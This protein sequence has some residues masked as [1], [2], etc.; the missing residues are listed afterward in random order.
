V[1]PIGWAAAMNTPFPYY[2]VIAS[3]LGGTRTGMVI[4]WPARIQAR[5]VRRQFVDITDITPTILDTIG[6]TPPASIA[7]ALQTPF[8][9]VSFADSFSS[10]NAPSHHDTQYFEIFGNAAIYQNGWLL[11]ERVRTDPMRGAA[12]PD[13]T[14]PWQLYDLTHDFSQTVDVASSH[15]D[16]VA[17]MTSLWQTEAARNHVLPL[18]T[19]NLRAMLPGT[20][21]EPLAE[22]GLYT[23]FSSSDRYPNGAFPQLHNRNW[24]IEADIDVPATGAE[25]VLATQG[26]RD[27]GWA[28]AL[29]KGV[30]TFF[31]RLNDRDDT[32]TRLADEH[33]LHTGHHS[34]KV[35]FT[36]DGP[37]F[38][39]GG[40]LALQVDGTETAVGRLENTVPFTFGSGDATIGRVTSTAVSDDYEPPYTFTGTLN[41]VTFDIGPVQSPMR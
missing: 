39:R 41:G 31:Y 32:L 25:G 19:N 16:T 37:G 21:P 11:A 13:M 9:G 35:I 8:D 30:P 1:G 28:L 5:G 17:Q 33:I 7:G 40:G 23:F 24:T 26:G 22:P 4:S 29:L 14:S 27:S 18:V 20:R 36:V 38:G 34:V 10:A 15:P 12:M 2:K 6:I 3:R